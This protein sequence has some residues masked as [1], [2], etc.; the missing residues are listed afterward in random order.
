MDQHFGGS[1]YIRPIYHYWF[2]NQDGGGYLMEVATTR[3]GFPQLR[4]LLHS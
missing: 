4:Q 3:V 1:P 2:T